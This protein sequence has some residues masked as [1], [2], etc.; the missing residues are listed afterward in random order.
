MSHMSTIDV[1]TAVEIAAPRIIRRAP[2]NT[3]PLEITP[4][5]KK[6]LAAINLE[7]NGNAAEVDRQ[8]AKITSA[9]QEAKTDADRVAN[10]ADAAKIAKLRQL[11]K[12]GFL[13]VPSASI[14]HQ[15]RAFYAAV[16]GIEALLSNNLNAVAQAAV[17]GLQESDEVQRSS[18]LILSKQD[19]AYRNLASDERAGLVEMSRRLSLAARPTRESD[20]TK[21]LCLRAFVCAA[22]WADKGQPAMAKENY[23]AIIRAL[24][25]EDF[26]L[27]SQITWSDQLCNYARR[28][29]QA[30]VRIP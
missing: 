27:R 12:V 20:V 16:V 14:I 4:T 2:V 10:A 3:N 7:F 13:N 9:M 22:I 15:I 26:D 1:S 8:I 30:K 21:A 5:E 17:M 29:A 18:E 23:G 6:L 25:R 28:H 19:G 11:R 24:H